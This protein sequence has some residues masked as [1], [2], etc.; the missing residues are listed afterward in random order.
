MHSQKDTSIGKQVFVYLDGK[1]L[2]LFKKK[3]RP[4]TA[5]IIPAVVLENMGKKVP[6]II[7]VCKK[8]YFYSNAPYGGHGIKLKAAD[9]AILTP[10]DIAWLEETTKE[11]EFEQFCTENGF[12]KKKF[13]IA[14]NKLL[15]PK[16]S[17]KK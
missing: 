3:L 11:E 6:K 17:K 15:R 2:K 7:V 13:R 4:K 16:K 9:P 5:I 12:D 10:R 8:K 1:N 14:L